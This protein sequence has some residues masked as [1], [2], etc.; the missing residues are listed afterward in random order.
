MK[1]SKCGSKM[2]VTN[3]LPKKSGEIIRYRKCPNCRLT[4]KTSESKVIT[5]IIDIAIIRG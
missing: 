3:S 4:V 2:K 5:E 1:C